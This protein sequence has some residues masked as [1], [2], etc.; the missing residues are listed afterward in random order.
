MAKGS[1]VVEPAN[2]MIASYSTWTMSLQARVPMEVGCFIK[3]SLPSDF[4]YNPTEVI[5]SGM[6]LPADFD[7][8]I[9]AEELQPMM[10][11]KKDD[12]SLAKSYVL[13]PGCND[14]T[15]IARTPFGRV[16]IKEIQTQTSVKDSGTFEIQIY[17][18]K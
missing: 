12:P 16:D 8:V 2:D 17:K 7:D 15:S 3:L 10:F 18:D 13:M 1:F 5:A 9:T 6:F 14:E 11:L 4:R